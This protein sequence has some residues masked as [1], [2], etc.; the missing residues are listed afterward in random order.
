MIKPS[1]LH[2]WLSPCKTHQR[3]RSASSTSGGLSTNV[4]YLAISVHRPMHAQIPTPNRGRWQGALRFRCLQSRASCHLLSTKRGFPNTYAS[5]TDISPSAAKS[6]T[7]LSLPQ[8][9]I[10]DLRE[11]ARQFVESRQWRGH[12]VV[13]ELANT[14]PKTCRKIFYVELVRATT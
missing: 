7:E 6:N 1:S 14:C 2:F 5:D 8:A 10:E 11:G 4:R 9:K 13:Q 3:D 12:L